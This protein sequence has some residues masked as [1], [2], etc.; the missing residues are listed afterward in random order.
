MSWTDAFSL[1][2]SR[3]GC[4][5]QGPKSP[6]SAPFHLGAPQPLHSSHPHPGLP[7]SFS[8]FPG[9]H[10]KTPTLSA[11]SAV[12]YLCGVR[13][14]Q[15]HSKAALNSP[16]LLCQALEYCEEL[17]KPRLW[18]LSPGP[19]GGSRRPGPARPSAAP[20]W[21]L[22]CTASDSSATVNRP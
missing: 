18:L 14:S 6:L 8:A 13:R 19:A 20:C 5:K 22:A 7:I 11:V 12:W 3:C 15:H 16:S 9:T 4:S 2:S 17:E 1:P 21:A 10:R